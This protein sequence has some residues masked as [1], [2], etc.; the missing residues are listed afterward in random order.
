MSQ[1]RAVCL[2]PD[3]IK[4][5]LIPHRHSEDRQT[6]E[7]QHVKQECTGKHVAQYAGL[8]LSV[9]QAE[10]GMNKDELCLL[11]VSFICMRCLHC[12]STPLKDLFETDSSKNMSKELV[13][14]EICNP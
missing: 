5:C 1:Q 6:C 7:L 14:D 4:V 2:Q 3:T 9:L 10:G 12:F 11:I 13:L 8:L